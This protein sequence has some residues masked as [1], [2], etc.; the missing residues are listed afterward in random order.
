M[1]RFG[2]YLHIPFCRSKCAYCDFASWAGREKWMERYAA[3]VC[4]EM[5]KR[6]AEDLEIIRQ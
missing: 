1:T 4:A 2:L 6:A 5:E 3:A